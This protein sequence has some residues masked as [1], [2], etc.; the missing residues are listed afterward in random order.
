MFLT[1]VVSFAAYVHAEKQIDRAH[2]LRYLSYQLAD[3]LRQSSDELTRMARTHVVTGDPIYRQFYLD[4]LHIRDGQKPRPDNDAYVYWDLVLAAPHTRH[5]GSGRAIP[6]LDLMRQ[7]G[8]SAEEFGKLAEAKANS[9]GLTAREFEAMRLA[10]SDALADQAEARRMLHDDAYHQ[11][12][13]AIMRPIKEF[14]GLMDRRTLTAV[15]HAEDMAVAF[16]TLFIAVTLA[17]FLVL[18]GTYRDACATLGG[19]ADDLHAQI[20]RIGRG[21]F[22]AA[23]P[24]PPGTENS[25]LAGLS[26]MQAKLNALDSARRKAEARLVESES[27]L[28]AIIENEP[29]CIKIVDAQ[30]RL[31]AMN[32][33]G[34][35]MI[36]ADSL[37]Q[38]A[39]KPVLNIVAP[40]YRAA[41]AEMHQ[42]VLAGEVMQLEF[43]VLGIKGG[44]RW[45][46]THAVPMRDH[47]SV[48]HLAVTRDISERKQAEKALRDQNEA[49]ERSNAELESFAYVASHDLREP[50][51]NVTAF[52]TLLARRLEGRLEA[53]E[54]DLLKIIT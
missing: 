42:R 20:T 53:D 25:V 35:G 52:S 45:L 8:Y 14:F 4:I 51:R 2:N 38:V 23:I 50:L 28:R 16:R 39:G 18:W 5:P 37:D 29:E 19:S 12:K 54:R 36:E 40:E 49:L 11:A 31:T 24:I 22:S 13:A 6:L 46:E 7:A 21:D 15:Q 1:L 3:Q 34:L 41:F 10:G 48:V 43:E 30:G 47:G 32:P 27:H 17:A 9:D 33:A 26:D 44:R